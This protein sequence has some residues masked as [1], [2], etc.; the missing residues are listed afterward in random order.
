M[1]TIK[2]L[3]TYVNQKID[4]HLTLVVSLNKYLCNVSIRIIS[5]FIK[6]YYN[7]KTYKQQYRKA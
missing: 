5:N 3:F 2:K 6:K 4:N 7:I 1:K